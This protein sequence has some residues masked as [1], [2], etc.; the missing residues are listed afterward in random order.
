ME[1]VEV[2]FKQSLG[3]ITL[4]KETPLKPDTLR[5]AVED[6]GFTPRWIELQTVGNVTEQNGT[7]IFQVDGVE[8]RFVLQENE[9]LEQL[10]KSGPLAGK[11]ITLTGR[12]QEE[13]ESVLVL[14]IK[15]FVVK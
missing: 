2:I 14:S 1:K 9:S 12:V 13:E 4:K 6:A 11:T 10:K 5:K 8:Q 15:E 7:W 3:V